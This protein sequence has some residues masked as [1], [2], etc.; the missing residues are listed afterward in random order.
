MIEPAGGRAP[1]CRQ[2]IA[3]TGSIAPTDEIKTP[4]FLRRRDRGKSALSIVSV[5]S[6]SR[7][8]GAV[9]ARCPLRVWRLAELASWGIISLASGTREEYDADYQKALGRVFRGNVPEACPL[10]PKDSTTQ[11]LE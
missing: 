2:I 10:H 9:F 4:R 3:P 8:S 6:I 7:A 11:E 5:V 1:R